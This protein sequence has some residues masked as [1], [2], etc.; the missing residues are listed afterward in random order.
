MNDILKLAASTI[1]G[2]EYLVSLTGAGISKESNVPTFR[3]AD[4]LW[5]NHDA[6]ELAT[7]QAFRKD[8]KLVWEWYS[9]R[10]GLIAECSPNPGHDTLAKW[11]QQGLLKCLITQNVDGLHRRAKSE[12]VLEVHGDLW[13]IKCT[14]CSYHSRLSKPADGIPKCPECGSKLRPDV[15]WF[16]ES[17][18]PE[19]MKSVYRELELADTIIVIGTSALVQPAASFPLLVK[20]QGGKIIELNIEETPLTR[21]VDVHIS[22]PSGVMLPKI[23]ELLE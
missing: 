22:G 4:G 13:A 11:E 18:N 21:Y 8:S 17:L 9:W 5:K 12:K 1:Q 19:I 23:D 14:E 3:G 2:S 10:Q 6:M 7:P 15:V 20:Q 16:G